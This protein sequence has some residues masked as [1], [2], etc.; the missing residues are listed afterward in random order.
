MLLW[1]HGC[2]HQA[3][4]DLVQELCC[5]GCNSQSRSAS[6]QCSFPTYILL[7]LPTL[8]SSLWWR[9][10]LACYCCMEGSMVFVQRSARKTYLRES[11][12]QQFREEVEKGRLFPEL[13]SRGMFSSPKCSAFCQPLQIL[14]FCKNSNTLKCLS[15]KGAGL[16]RTRRKTVFWY[17]GC[18]QEEA[19][20]SAT[21]FFY[22]QSKG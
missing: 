15:M 4:S 14:C 18:T 17:L 20:S 2:T 19:N 12:L 11:D 1:S 16:D 22:P 5:T 10:I 9:V 13:H 21:K 6:A 3:T 8:N 7:I